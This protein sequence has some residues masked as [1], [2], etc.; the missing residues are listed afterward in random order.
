M[1]MYKDLDIMIQDASMTS[2]AY[3]TNKKMISDF[4]SGDN[5][6]LTQNLQN[7]IHTWEQEQYENYGTEIVRIEKISLSR[8]QF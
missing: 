7:V 5:K 2:E 6:S 4:L 3:E 1:G 8:I